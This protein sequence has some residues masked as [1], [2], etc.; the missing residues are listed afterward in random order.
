MDLVGAQV[1]A[2]LKTKKCEKRPILEASLGGQILGELTSTRPPM[3]QELTQ[4]KLN[5]NVDC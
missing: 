4:T 3:K 2:P 1:W 5:T